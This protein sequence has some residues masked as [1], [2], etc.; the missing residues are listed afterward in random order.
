MVAS[1]YESLEMGGAP[2]EADTFD[3]PALDHGVAIDG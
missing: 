2:K 1:V 3:A